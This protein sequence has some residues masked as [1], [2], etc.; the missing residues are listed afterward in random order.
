M[1]DLL[2]KLR[3]AV[4]GPR[5]RALAAEL[6]KWEAP[7]VTFVAE[8]GSFPVFW[9]RGDGCLIED[10]DGNRLLDLTAA[11]GVA[12]LGHGAPVIADAIARQAKRLVHGMGDV[13]PTEA[14]V[15]LARRIADFT[16]DG[17][18]V[19]Q[20]GSSG[21]DAVEIALKTARLATGKSG[22]IAFSGGY[23]GLNLGALAVTHRDDF[24]QP[25]SRWV[26]GFAQHLPYGEPIDSLPADTAAVLVEPI[27]GRGGVVL[28]PI[29]WLGHLRDRCDAA[30]ALLIFDEIFTGWGRTGQWFAANDEG[31]VP[32]LL[33]VG[34]ALGGGLPLSACVGKRA[35]MDAWGAS[36]GEALHTSTFLGNPLACA[37]G[38]AVLDALESIDAPGLAAR[39]GTR[40]R[41]LLAALRARHPG[42]VKS[43]RGRGL[44]IGMVLNAPDLGPLLA[45]R[46]LADGLI[47]LPAGDGSVLEI[48]PPLVI[49]DVQS[50]WAA[51]RI[52]ATL[53]NL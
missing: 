18:D 34:K 32:D 31:V 3:T 14:K 47:A 42:K 8:D 6:R 35:V 37:A 4:P 19:S 39:A 12:A 27:Q 43:I 10:A 44:M 22:V 48:T 13:H 33:C 17:L 28:P 20:F 9:E 25:F 11:F 7:H 21:G 53:A 16:P 38:L 50:E 26:P 29:G 30:G 24:R 46:L 49:R 45:T 23:H 1:G 5:S 52:D 36:T 41:E 15:A 51:D 2:P 40:W